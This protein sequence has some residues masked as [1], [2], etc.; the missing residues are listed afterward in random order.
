MAK[1]IPIR[2]GSAD[3]EIVS[4]GFG[5]LQIKTR[6]PLSNG[7]VFH[8]DFPLPDGDTPIRVK[9]KVVYVD[10]EGMGIEFV[11]LKV[12]DAERIGVFLL[13]NR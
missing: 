11:D 3:S 4:L 2:L 8:L 12:R 7:T 13:I 5:G 6:A 1:A 9:A 10:R